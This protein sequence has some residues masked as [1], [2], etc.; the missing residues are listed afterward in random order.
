MRI[1]VK[2]K[3]NSKQDIVETAGN[4][5]FVIKVKATATEGRAN[6]RLIELLSKHLK[7][8]K[9]N[10]SI[11]RGLKSKNKIIDIG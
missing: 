1:A 9:R 2:I 4:N 11:I 3:S 7:I 10:I 5:E 8:P 6:E